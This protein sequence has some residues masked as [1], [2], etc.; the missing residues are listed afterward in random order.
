MFTHLARIDLQTSGTKRFWQRR[1]SEA[2]VLSLDRCVGL[3]A[4]RK[5]S[6][7]HI[8]QRA[9]PRTDRA[10]LQTVLFRGYRTEVLAVTAVL[11]LQLK[12][13]I[14]ITGQV[15]FAQYVT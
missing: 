13:T 7:T 3:E 4:N 15:Q 10:A 8:E 2:E 5:A 11:P 14:G 6:I 9:A 1:R 12:L